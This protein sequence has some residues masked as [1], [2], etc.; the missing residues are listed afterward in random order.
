MKYFILFLFFSLNLFNC[1]SNELGALNWLNKQ[2]NSNYS[3]DDLRNLTVLPFSN[4]KHFFD[5]DLRHLKY[6]PNLNKLHLTGN[7]SDKGL[8]YLKYNHQ[9]KELFIWWTSINGE[10]FKYL[11]KLEKLALYDVRVNLE[12]LKYLNNLKSISILDN[13]FGDFR[14]SRAQH[15]INHSDP[16]MKVVDK[17]FLHFKKLKKLETLIIFSP[18]ISDNCLGYLKNFKQ[19]HHLRLMSPKITF[20]GLFKL[21]D[22]ENIRV[23]ILPQ[24]NFTKNDQKK[25][26][27]KF[28]NCNLIFE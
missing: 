25:L 19:L 16:L 18:L 22:L 14:I 26:I 2:A 27:E 15:F 6:I 9:L 13:S 12:N 23:F 7:I 5:H 10:G 3:A 8:K 21:K 20:Q 28:P 4:R 11:K 24:E 17:D 1:N